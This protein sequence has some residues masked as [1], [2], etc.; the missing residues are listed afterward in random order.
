MGQALSLSIA[1]RAVFDNVSTTSAAT[2]S[3]GSPR[4]AW[5]TC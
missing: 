3:A 5:P 1:G 2:T 4:V